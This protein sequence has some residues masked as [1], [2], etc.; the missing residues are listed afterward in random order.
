MEGQR[1]VSHPFGS[2]EPA[3]SPW[4]RHIFKTTVSFDMFKDAIAEE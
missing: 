3:K 4:L 1:I 2:S